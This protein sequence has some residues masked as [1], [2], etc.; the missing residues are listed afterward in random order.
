MFI[1]VPFPVV[2]YIPRSLH[3]QFNTREPTEANQPQ[4]DPGTTFC[5]ESTFN[6]IPH[7]EYKALL[8]TCREAD[9]GEE[10]SVCVEVLKHALDRLP[11]DPERHAGSSQIQTAADHIIRVQQVLVD[12]SHGPRDTA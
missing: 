11:I 7:S 9:N 2:I 12:G 4:Q 6:S 10:E 3:F 1:Y 8:D 5:L